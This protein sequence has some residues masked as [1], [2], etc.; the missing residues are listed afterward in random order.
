MKRKSVEDALTTQ[1]NTF[2]LIVGVRVHNARAACVTYLW[3][4]SNHSI[5]TGPSS[6][7]GLELLR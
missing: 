2:C 7:S 6:A 5:P 3:Y 1:H 4:A